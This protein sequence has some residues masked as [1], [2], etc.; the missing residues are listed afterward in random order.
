MIDDYKKQDWLQHDPDIHRYRL[1]THRL[2]AQHWDF[3]RGS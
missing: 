1:C 2:T 3:L